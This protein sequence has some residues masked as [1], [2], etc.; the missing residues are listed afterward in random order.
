MLLACDLSAPISGSWRPASL[1][2]DPTDS[3]RG[4]VC[5]TA[6]LGSTAQGDGGQ[7]WIVRAPGITNPPVAGCV[8]SNRTGE[9]A[10]A[11]CPFCWS[12]VLDRPSDFLLQ[13]LEKSAKL[14]RAA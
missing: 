8:R 10:P 2:V 14:R 13:L 12:S 1:L 3:P 9:I 7:T 11:H 4:Y 5:C 6:V